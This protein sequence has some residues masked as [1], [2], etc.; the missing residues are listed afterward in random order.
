MSDIQ[1]G[2][3][4]A[5]QPLPRRDPWASFATYGRPPALTGGPVSHRAEISPGRPPWAGGRGRHRVRPSRTGWRGLMA[6]LGITAL[7]VGSCGAPAPAAPPAATTSWAM[8]TVPAV[9]QRRI[10][11]VDR[12]APTAWNVRGAVNWLD[13]Y[14]GSDMVVVA[15]CSGKAYR[16]ITVRGGKLS[17]NLVGWS[18]GSTITIDTGKVARSKYRS[19]VYRD[20]LLIH[21]LA[22]Q[23]GLGHTSSVG[24]MATTVDRIRLS[25]TAAQRA[26]LRAR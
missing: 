13:R 26:Y 19:A 20:R 7:A 12:I 9:T 4:G 24:L 21:E 25:L 18:S 2:S 16:C 15:K 8:P 3:T 22:H 6:V 11:I 1:T 14:T 17:G 5:V 10:E 23:H